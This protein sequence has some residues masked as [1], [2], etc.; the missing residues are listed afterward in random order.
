MLFIDLVHKDS[1]TN[2]TGVFLGVAG[3]GEKP[4]TENIAIRPRNKLFGEVILRNIPEQP[5]GYK[6]INDIVIFFN[7][8]TGD[9]SLI[10]YIVKDV[11]AIAEEL[12]K[13]REEF[14]IK[15]SVAEEEK[16]RAKEKVYEEITKA[17]NIIEKKE[18]LLPRRKMLSKVFGEEF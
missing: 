13:K 8:G 5:Y 12:K 18:E 6:V 4:H 2:L 1:R 11:R 17:K 15:L 14:E 3:A 10:D 16:R 7:D 9:E